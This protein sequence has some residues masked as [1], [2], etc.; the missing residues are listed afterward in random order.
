MDGL[1]NGLLYGFG[2]FALGMFFLWIV[3]LFEKAPPAT[4]LRTVY[5]VAKIQTISSNGFSPVGDR[6]TVDLSL[7]IQADD[8][9]S[10]VYVSVKQYSLQ[11]IHLPQVQPGNEVRVAFD[12]KD[13]ENFAIVV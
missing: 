7:S 12:P 11:I 1:A 5:G 10:A 9:E 2:A 13:P 8:S 4:E 3:S 6:I